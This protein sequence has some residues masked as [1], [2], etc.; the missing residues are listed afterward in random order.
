[1]ELMEKF[2]S[3][4]L[5][6]DNRLDE[7]DRAFCARNQKAYENAITAYT[8]LLSAWSE[9]EDTQRWLMED[10]P[11]Y[12][13][14]GGEGT[15]LSVPRMLEHIALLHR[16]FI[17]RIVCR[18]YQRYRVTFSV[19][20]LTDKLLPKRPA[21][22]ADEENKKAYWETICTP[23]V[24]FKDVFDLIF[25]EM[26]GRDFPQYAL[27]QLKKDCREAAW[28][29]RSTHLGCA[30]EGDTVHF[31]GEFCRS[32]T[33]K[34][35]YYDRVKVIWDLT[36]KMEKILYGAA[37]YETGR[38]KEYPA[39]LNDLING[40]CHC[41]EQ[42]KFPGMKKL[43]GLR[44]Y[45]TGCVDVVFTSAAFAEGFVGTYLNEAE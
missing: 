42:E 4:E 44:L 35:S 26:G 27:Y 34:D 9:L 22:D 19:S 37:H 20:Q 33:E 28:E 8:G 29:T 6:T 5:E 41:S 36:E 18:L 31:L 7:E 30:V 32:F 39:H 11:R 12:Y 21:A 38:F 14:F 17:E 3:V 45:E 13:L 2:Q 25:A 15:T 40:K 1:M 43:R 10:W 23:I 16:L 24:H